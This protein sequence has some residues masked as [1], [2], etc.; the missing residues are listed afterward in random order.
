M[1]NKSLKL[2]P[3]AGCS[4]RCGCWGSVRAG[5]SAAKLN[6]ML[7]ATGIS[8]FFNFG[9]DLLLQTSKPGYAPLRNFSGLRDS[10]S[11][12]TCLACLGQS[13]AVGKRSFGGRGGERT[14]VIS[15]P[16]PH[17]LFA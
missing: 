12:G 15:A 1:Y 10:T 2:T 17:T 5:E 11:F 6:S 7:C 9:Y 14:F 4:R 16:A 3:W 8:E 13:A